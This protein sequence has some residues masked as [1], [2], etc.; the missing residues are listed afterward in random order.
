[1]LHREYVIA[2]PSIIP[3]SML[4]THKL[5]RPSGVAQIPAPSLSSIHQLFLQAA[6]RL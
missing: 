5:V 6:L 3:G 2:D 4:M 1:M